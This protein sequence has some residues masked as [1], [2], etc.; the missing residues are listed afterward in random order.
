[1][2]AAKTVEEKKLVLGGL[3]TVHDPMALDLI[4]PFT[5][6]PAVQTEAMHAAMSLAPYVCAISPVITRS[7]LQTVMDQSVDKE[8][9]QSARDLAQTMG[10]FEDFIMVWQVSEPFFQE[11]KDGRA[12][13]DLAFAP[14]QPVTSKVKWQ[15][16]PVGGR[17]DRPWMLDLGSFYGGDN[18]VAYA[19][20]WLFADAKQP[21]RLE[22]GSDDGLKIWLNG[23]LAHAANKGGD[24][25]PGDQKVSVILQQGSNELLL[26]V[27]QWT[28][29]W[30]F[31][32][33][34]TKPDG[35]PLHGVHVALKPS[36]QN[37]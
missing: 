13:F 29:G 36:I 35:S 25:I 18:R 33:R 2:A 32:A 21:V 11:G 6:D 10:K 23:E 3:A 30:G 28:S 7:I 16:L 22:F 27:T 12:L 19:R 4:K 1:V 24:V 5:A 9:I 37:N 34:A 17:K 20:T 14:E 15:L 8:I 31:C 26:K